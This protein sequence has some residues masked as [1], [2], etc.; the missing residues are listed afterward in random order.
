[1]QDQDEPRDE[2][3]MSEQAS[4]GSAN[5]SNGNDRMDKLVN[6]SEVDAASSDNAS[7][8]HHSNDWKSKSM[9][10]KQHEDKDNTN[11]FPNEDCDA[12]PSVGVGS[13]DGDEANYLLRGSVENGYLNESLNTWQDI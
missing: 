2:D 11:I 7:N 5:E 8:G 9:S 4:I 13:R 3:G 6:L 1:M 10:V 12:F